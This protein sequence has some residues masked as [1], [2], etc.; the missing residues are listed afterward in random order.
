[1]SCWDDVYT[2][3][4]DLGAS[5]HSGILHRNVHS[6]NPLKCVYFTIVLFV[7][8]IS[9]KLILFRYLSYLFSKGWYMVQEKV[10]FR[11]ALIIK[12]NEHCYTCL[13]YNHLYST[14]L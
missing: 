11:L 10:C 9:S 1:M 7:L 6:I 3:T 2:Y 4:K 13:E 8:F 14:F 12:C 5:V